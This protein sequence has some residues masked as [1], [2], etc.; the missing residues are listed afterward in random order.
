VDTVSSSFTARSTEIPDDAFSSPSLSVYRESSAPSFE[1]TGDAFSSP[2]LSVYREPSSPSFESNWDAFCSPSLSVYKESRRPS[3]NF[4][5]SLAGPAG[6]SQIPITCPKVHR[7]SSAES[8]LSLSACRDHSQFMYSQGIST[9]L[10]EKASFPTSPSA[11][12]MPFHRERMRSQPCPE[13]D[14]HERCTYSNSVNGPWAEEKCREVAAALERDTRRAALRLGAADPVVEE[15][16]DRIR[17]L[18]NRA[19]ALRWSS[20]VAQHRLDVSNSERALEAGADLSVLEDALRRAACSELGP[21]HEIVQ[22]GKQLL[23]GYRIKQSLQR[24][25]SLSMTRMNN[26]SEAIETGDVS[27]ISQAIIEASNVD[28]KHIPEVNAARETMRRMRTGIESNRRMALEED[29]HALMIQA[30]ATKDIRLINGRIWQT[31]HSELG[32]SHPIVN[33]GKGCV[34]TLRLQAKQADQDALREEC[35]SALS[36]SQQ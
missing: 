24:H 22:H 2:S 12:N 16:H 35:M 31:A 11:A 6:R 30:C 17:Q 9:T 1:S 19:D 33:I 13:H 4:G 25:S 7:L 27:A 26:I 28:I 14:F 8:S 20:V 32:F 18:R 29:H 21:G 23:R 10:S 15:V 5:V 3:W 36:T 34:R